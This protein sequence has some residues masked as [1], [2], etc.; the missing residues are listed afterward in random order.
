[1]IFEL[2]NNIIK[3]QNVGRYEADIVERKEELP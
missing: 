1:M 3:F 2:S